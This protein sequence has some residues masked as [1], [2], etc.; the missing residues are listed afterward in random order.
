[1]FIPACEFAGMD[2]AELAAAGAAHDGAH[3]PDPPHAIAGPVAKAGPAI[4]INANRIDFVMIIDLSKSF[5]AL[6]PTTVRWAMKRLE[7]EL[8]R[9]FI[10]GT[11]CKSI[12]NP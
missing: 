8:K 5:H 12:M 4:V 7:T 6:D 2:T 1:M 3:A 9:T 11:T 10:A